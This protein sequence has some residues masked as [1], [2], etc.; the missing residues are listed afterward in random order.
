MSKHHIKRQ[1]LMSD[2]GELCDRDLRCAPVPLIGSNSFD[3]EP[4]MA[5][6]ISLG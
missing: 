5:F 1:T 4:F 6:S 2:K 3:A